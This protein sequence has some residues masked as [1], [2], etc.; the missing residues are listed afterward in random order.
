MERLVERGLGAGVEGEVGDVAAVRAD[1]VMMMSG[2]MLGEL[3]AGE[4][5]AGHDPGDDVGFFE[6]GQVAVDGGLRK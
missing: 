5:V 1:Q 2:E 4:V 6:G 3:V